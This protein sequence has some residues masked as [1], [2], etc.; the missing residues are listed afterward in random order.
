MLHEPGIDERI[1]RT[2]RELQLPLG[3]QLDDRRF[4]LT[5]QPARSRVPPPASPT[6][7]R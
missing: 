6:S 1:K 5:G 4:S 2:A 3:F 7:A